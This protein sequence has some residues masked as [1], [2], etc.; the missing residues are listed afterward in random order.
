VVCFTCQHDFD[1]NV[2]DCGSSTN[3]VPVST[4]SSANA[5]ESIEVCY[6]TV[7][8]TEQVHSSVR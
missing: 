6:S 5:A 1:A 2:D 7:G 3:S 4:A 8:K